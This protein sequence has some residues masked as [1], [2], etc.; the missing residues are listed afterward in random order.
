[1]PVTSSS[2][3]STALADAPI[4]AHVDRGGFVESV[5]RGTVVVTAPDGTVEWALGDPTGAVFA[6]S[7]NKPIQAAAM[8]RLGLD[9]PDAELALACASHSGEPFHRE[10]AVRVLERAGLTEADLQNTPDYPIDEAEQDAWIRAGRAKSAVAQNCSGKHAAMLATCVLNGWDPAAYRHPEHPL[11]R[12]ITETIVEMSGEPVV[13]VTVDRCGAPHHAYAIAGLARAFGRIA[14]APDGTAEA[15]VTTAI[16]AEPLYLGGTRRDVTQLVREAPGLIAKDG[17]ESVY[18][19]GLADGRGVAVKIA[20]GYPRA[21]AVVLAAVLR[22]LGVD[23]AGA[24]D[25]LSF[26]PV[27]GHGDP[28]GGI[29][30]VGF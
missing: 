17:A 18:A 1:V 14:A 19:V 3:V 13:A 27:L 9:L 23:A 4:V 6:R 28:V 20:D 11:Q 22:R 7:A 24:L 5:H 26:A 25:D 12:V 10:A 29:V 2:E 15:R 16:R 30:A 21:K 8:V